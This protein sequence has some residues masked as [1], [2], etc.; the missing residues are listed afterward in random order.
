[1]IN[2]SYFKICDHGPADRI[3]A[4]NAKKKERFL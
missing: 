3:N 2:E 1:M 4:E